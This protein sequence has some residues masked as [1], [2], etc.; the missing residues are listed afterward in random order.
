[1]PMPQSPIHKILGRFRGDERRPPT[2][3]GGLPLLGHTVKFMRDPVGMI[4]E[5][6]DKIGDAFTV[7]LFGNH[8]VVLPTPDGAETLFRANDKQVSAKEAYKLMTP[9]FGKGIAYDAEPDIMDEQL[10]FF[11]PALRKQRMDTYA[12]QMRLETLRYVEQWGDEGEIDLLDMTNELTMY[13]SSRCLLCV[14]FRDYLN[15]EFSQLY[16]D[17]EL[18]VAP[19]A[20]YFP[21]APVPAFIRRDKARKRMG[22]LIGQIVADRKR[23]NSQ[24]EDFLQTLMDARYKDGKPLSDDEIAGLLLAIVFAGHHTSAV[25]AAWTGIELLQHPQYLPDVLEEQNRV[26]G[27]KELSAESLKQLPHLE[28]ILFECERLH[29]PLVILLRKTLQ[30]LPFRDYVIPAGDMVISSPAVSNRD[31]RVFTNPHVFQPERFAPGREEHKKHPYSITSF[32][33]GKHI[34]IGMNFAR[35]QI[36]AI[37]SLLL[38]Q[39]E[40]ELSSPS[41][42]PSFEFLVV[43]PR[44]PCKVRYRRIKRDTSV[45][46]SSSSR[47]QPTQLSV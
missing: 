8:A 36:K 31:P 42:E 16:Q 45:K 43:G 23:T 30:D 2:L 34:C 35:M 33:G 12:E 6:R 21:N 32:G 37:W 41:Y 7:Q 13:I 19:L 22:E 38:T 26:H 20:Y 1:M 47:Q 44:K 14:E 27:N 10:A 11:V 17:L 25:L 40:F 29:P 24:H 46:A 3:P 9:I 4:Y 15:A 39:F 28:R 5:G 18:G